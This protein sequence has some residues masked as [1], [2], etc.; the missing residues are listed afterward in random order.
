MAGRLQNKVAVITG[1]TSGIGE[2]TAEF[3]I[4]EGANVVI[5]GRSE[6]KGAAV[7]NRLGDACQFIT[8]DVMREDDIAKTIAFAAGT[9]GGI[10][11]LFNNS[12]GPVCFMSR[13]T[14]LGTD[15]LNC[16]W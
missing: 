16:K 1:G 8:A 13:K 6:E 9:F 2:A 15:K 14:N 3:F 7:A 5:C 12:G 4:S 11:I 10:D